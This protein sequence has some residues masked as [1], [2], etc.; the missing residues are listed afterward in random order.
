MGITAGQVGAYE[1]ELCCTAIGYGSFNPT[2]GNNVC[3]CWSFLCC[4]S[5]KHS[6]PTGPLWEPVD[7][8]R[9]SEL[10]KEATSVAD[11]VLKHPNPK[12]IRRSTCC[13]NNPYAI[14]ST[15]GLDWTK[16]ANQFHLLTIY[17]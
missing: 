7:K 16:K 3:C 10:L 13:D 1:M 14:Q 5:C 11:S 2:F 17:E 12:P 4:Y 6:P 9:W 15:L 8:N